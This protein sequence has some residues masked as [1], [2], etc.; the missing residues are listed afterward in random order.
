MTMQNMKLKRILGFTTNGRNSFVNQPNSNNLIYIAGCVVVIFNPETKVQNHL[1]TESKQNITTLAVSEDGHYLAASNCG[2]KAKIYI[3]DLTNLNLIGEFIAHNVEVSCMSFSTNNQFLV[4]VGS[5]QDMI[6][7]I[8]DWQRQLKIAAHKVA[9]KIRAVSFSHDSSYFVTVGQSYIKFWYIQPMNSCNSG[10]TNDSGADVNS[11]NL[12]TSSSSS[13]SYSITNRSATLGEQK[14]NNFCDVK[15]GRGPM[16]GSTFCI[17]NSGLLCQLNSKRLLHKWVDLRVTSANCMSLGDNII[18]IGCAN[19]VSRCFNTTELRFLKN[20]PKPHSLGVDSVNS[21]ASGNNK[22]NSP[23]TILKYPNIIGVGLNEETNSIACVHNDR[24]IY[25][26]KLSNSDE[27][28]REYSV[29]Y[30][31]S[32]IWGVAMYPSC[33]K[34][35]LPQGSFI[36]C[37]SDDTLRIWD[38]SSS[39]SIYCPESLKIIFTDSTYKYLCDLDCS[40]NKIDQNYDTIE[41]LRC[42]KVSPD[43]RQVAVGS[44]AGTIRIFNFEKSDVEM[45]SIAAHDAE[46]LCLEYSDPRNFDGFCYLASSSRD[47]LIHIFDALNDYNFL[48]TIDD[49]SSSIT[50]IR[51]VNN[52]A[53]DCLQ[54]ISCSADQ[55][56]IFRKGIKSSQTGQLSFKADQMIEG[57]TIFY[58][59]EV[60]SESSCLMTACQDRIIRLFNV[61]QVKY[62]SGFKSSCSDEGTI[63]K[64]ALDPSC[65]FLA[66]SSTDKSINIYDYQRGECIA[67][68]SYGLSDLVTDLKFS[69][70]GRH[71]IACSG[72]GCIFI[73]SSP[74]EIANAAMGGNLTLAQLGSYSNHSSV[75]RIRSKGDQS[76]RGSSS[77]SND[78]NELVEEFAEQQENIQYQVQ[79]ALDNEYSE[80]LSQNSRNNNQS[81]YKSVS[82]LTKCFQSRDNL[83]KISLRERFVNESLMHKGKDGQNSK[84]N[85]S[86]SGIFNKKGE[87]VATNKPILATKDQSNLSQSTHALNYTDRQQNYDNDQESDT[88]LNSLDVA[89]DLSNNL[90]LVS[91]SGVISSPKPSLLRQQ[92]RNIVVPV[93]ARKESSTTMRSARSECNLEN[94]SAQENSR[95]PV[96]DLIPGLSYCEKLDLSKVNPSNVAMTQEFCQYVVEELQTISKYATRLHQRLQTSGDRALCSLLARGVQN[97]MDILSIVPPRV[98][99]HHQFQSQVNLSSATMLSRRRMQSPLQQQQ[100]KKAAL[101]TLPNKLYQRA[102]N[103]RG[104]D[105]EEA[106]ALVKAKAKARL[107]NNETSNEEVETVAKSL[108]SKSNLMNIDQVLEAYSDRLFRLVQEKMSSQAGVDHLNVGNKSEEEESMKGAGGNNRR[109]F[110]ALSLSSP[111]ASA[112]PV[113]TLK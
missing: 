59:M 21:K 30:H 71:L 29:L 46:V 34:P 99:Q 11:S 98:S 3:W 15:C 112:S 1:V 36:T 94:C 49:H 57:K 87:Q 39:T 95:R 75:N 91:R 32:C 43:G 107:N 109:P 67:S 104:A 89:N 103:L 92:R 76:N 20:L 108:R 90:E 25:V 16:V 62:Q 56:I 24:S 102:P 6:V 52:R 66:A 7:C 26:W 96:L 22:N 4:S 38:P 5:Q 41:G 65:T 69:H 14:K 78:F 79:N 2:I 73:W 40:E 17:T 88:E 101:E 61:A 12:S 93:Q 111:T 106:A 27:I 58:D 47:K 13:S 60:D 82:S 54:L 33:V 83:D 70:D 84:I 64:I 45:K 10:L 28:V 48:Q 74:A 8:W 86:L 19:G 97:S 100:L 23:K 63:I 113:N 44:R 85:S 9:T 81:G 55:T 68:V 51:F 35:S 31:S 105:D 37:S 50:A 72:D 77:D 18:V 80:K 53:K 42:L 110:E